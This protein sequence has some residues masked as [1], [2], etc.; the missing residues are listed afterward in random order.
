MTLLEPSNGLMVTLEHPMRALTPGQ[1][2]V[3]YRGEVCLG[4]AKIFKQ[5]LS[6]YEQ[7]VTERIKIPAGLT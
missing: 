5:G 2:A 3:F 6:L 7:N 4:S 1:Y